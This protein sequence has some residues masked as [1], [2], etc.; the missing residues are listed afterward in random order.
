MDFR[1]L[2]YFVAV[3]EE[4][5]V[6][7]ASRRVLVAQP[8]LTRQIKL[9]EG[10]LDTQLF[11]RHAQGMQ[12]TV[13]GQAL[14]EEAQELLERRQQVMARV[15]SIG[16]GLSGKLSL[17][18]TVT[19]LWLP[20]VSGLLGAYRQRYSDVAFEV[21]PLLSGP[22]LDRLQ[23]G[24]LDAGILYLGEEAPVGLSTKL[25]HRDHLI[26][27]VPEL[28][29][30]ATFPPTKLAELVDEACIGGFRSASPIYHDRLQAHFQRYDFRPR[31]VQ[32]GADN[33][34]ILSMVAAGLGFTILPAAGS[35]TIIPGVRFVRMEELDA[36]EMPL[37]F[38]WRSENES[39]TLANMVALV[40][41]SLA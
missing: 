39:P 25:L 13:A 23:H 4:G 7:G 17:G 14:Y 16:N 35:N 6:S 31:L 20:M 37:W 5:S 12:L 19:H 22:Q 2:K 32:Y 40:E 29:P 8:A 1:Q 38:A 10:T 11:N 26:L 18:I 24:K 33:I 36:C 34:A 27:A 15:A 28:S 41:E 3:V 21:F 9:L 30:L